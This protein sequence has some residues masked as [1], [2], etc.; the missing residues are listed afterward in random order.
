VRGDATV[1][2]I[3]APAGIDP[4]D[5]GAGKTSLIVTGDGGGGG[6]DEDEGEGTGAEGCNSVGIMYSV[7]TTTVEVVVTTAALVVGPDRCCS[8]LSSTRIWKP[9]FSS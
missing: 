3:H 9:R 1:R 8:P 6:R 4:V 2:V 7:W 5:A